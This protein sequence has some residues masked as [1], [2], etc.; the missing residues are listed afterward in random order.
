M[1]YTLILLLM[2]N[3]SVS[4]QDTLQTPV[5]DLPH[6][7][8]SQTKTGSDFLK[9]TASFDY[10]PRQQE[11]VSWI[12][13]GNVPSFLRGLIPVQFRNDRGETAKIWVTADY[14]SIG[15]NEDFIRIP[16][17]KP[18][19]REIARATNMYLPTSVM[20]DSIYAKA[21]TRLNPIPM[22]PGEQM[23]SNDYY[24]RHNKMIEEQLAGVE[25]G[26]LVAGHKK[27]VV[28]TNRLTQQGGRVAI[29]G[30]HYAVDDPI[31]PLS[32]VHTEDYEDY[33]HGLR[34]VY[35][36]AEVN[37]VLVELKKLM[38]QPEW[39][40]TFTREGTIDIDHL[41]HGE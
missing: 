33:S 19:S 26:R 20:V 29:Y 24:R 21:H 35:P 2:L 30:W 25:N 28:I 11:A 38:N 27:D 13:E 22:K 40:S 23:R 7:D 34:L 36:V 3:T 10:K 15:T 9:Q 39:N 37:G 32:T 41:S 18:S 31:Q 17:S 14:M 1:K 12:L 6:P 8:V 5:L 16:L 4:A